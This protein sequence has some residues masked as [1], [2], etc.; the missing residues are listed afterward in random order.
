MIRGVLRQAAME[1]RSLLLLRW[2]LL[3]PAAASVWMLL[4]TWRLR[5]ESSQ[6]VNLYASDTHQMLLMLT[7]AIPLLLGVLLM[8]RDLLHPSAE[9]LFRLPLSAGSWMAAKWLAGLA[10]MTLY[11]AAVGAAYA[12]SALRHGLAFSSMWRHIALYGLL[13]EH[14]FALSLALGLFLGVLLPLRFSLPAAFCAW[15]FGSLFL[16]AYI[17]PVYEWSWLK[18]FY[19]QPLFENSLLGNEVWSWP[20]ARGELLRIMGF[21]AAFSLFLL[22]AGAALLGRHKPPLNRRRPWLLAIVAMLTAAAAF[23]P[24]AS[25]EAA[26]DVHRAQLEQMAAAPDERLDPASYRFRLER[27]DLQVELAG[28]AG[29]E[30]EATLELPTEKG[31][32]LPAEPGRELRYK[33][34]GIVSLLLYPSLQVRSVQLNGVPVAWERKGDSIRFPELMLDADRSVQ[35]IEIRYGGALDEWLSGPGGSESYLAFLR[36]EALYLPASLGWYPLPGGDTLLALDEDGRLLDRPASALTPD[37]AYTVVVSGFRAPLFGTLPDKPGS[38]GTMRFQGVSGAGLTLVGGRF[39]TVRRDGEPIRVV[40]TPGNRDEAEAFLERFEL[41]REGLEELAAS[42]L[43]AVRQVFFFPMHLIGAPVEA[44]SVNRSWHAENDTL[45]IPQTEHRNL[46]GYAEDALSDLLLFGDVGRGETMAKENALEDPSGGES[47]ALA[48][49]S[50]YAYLYNKQRGPDEP[51]RVEAEGLP[52]WKSM[53][54]LV[55]TAYERGDAP[56]VREVLEHFRGHGL[57]LPEP[58][59]S[60]AGERLAAD[61]PP[62]VTVKDFM[63]E[64]RERMPD[65]RWPRMTDDEG[66]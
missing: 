37:A 39:E 35:K 26:R 7:T 58:P 42:P 21:G 14:A 32:L 4:H 12:A 19:L 52:A 54:S 27:M 28:R 41:R 10:Y 43:N 40:T 48:I 2:T 55:Q 11:A 25:L 13:Y 46:D 60:G 45:F 20:L 66:G 17:R 56:L 5:P 29:L 18:A 9:W 15:V 44:P 23:A 59:R 57:T 6:D 65:D 34:P 63:R 64:W 51:Y 8:R 24:F 62:F 33:D 38:D 47:V 3:L 36:S 61:S 22:V 31:R 16:Q 30:V 50:A 49:R 53:R 1:L